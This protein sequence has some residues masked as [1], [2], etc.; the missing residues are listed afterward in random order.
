MKDQPYI[1]V[2]STQHSYHDDDSTQL[3][4]KKIIH[5]VKFMNWW[6]TMAELRKDVPMQ[7]QD[8]KL[9]WM[10]CWCVTGAWLDKI[11]SELYIFSNIGKERRL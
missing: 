10:T 9:T 6:C 8:L 7:K 5:D 3:N 4:E 2:P 11:G 1:Y